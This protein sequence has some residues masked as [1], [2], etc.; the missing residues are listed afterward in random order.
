MLSFCGTERAAF[1]IYVNILSSSGYIPIKHIDAECHSLMINTP[2]LYS[3]G[4]V[5]PRSIQANVGIIPADMPRP[6]P[7]TS[8]PVYH[9]QSS[10]HLALCNLSSWENIA[11]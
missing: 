5:F 1:F 4:H 10:C 9:S 2:A 7:S 8:F 3:G 6:F 11:K